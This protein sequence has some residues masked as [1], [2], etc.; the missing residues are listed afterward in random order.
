MIVYLYSEVT[1]QGMIVDRYREALARTQL[2]QKNI[3]EGI[4]SSCWHVV[5]LRVK[6]R[7]RE[8][9]GGDYHLSMK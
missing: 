6:G 5:R 2:L 3:V 7:G 4:E 1:R 8:R 9:G